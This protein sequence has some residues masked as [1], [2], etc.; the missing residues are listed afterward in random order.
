MR[1]KRLWHNIKIIIVETILA[2]LPE[3]MTNYEL[4]GSTLSSGEHGTPI[5]HEI[6]AAPSLTIDHSL[7]DGVRMKIIVEELIKLLFVRDTLLLVTGQLQEHPDVEV[8]LHMAAQD[9]RSFDC[10]VV[11]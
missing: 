5:L 11:A 4:S 9:R 3:L 8:P 1:T 10:F 2:M 6:N 7:T